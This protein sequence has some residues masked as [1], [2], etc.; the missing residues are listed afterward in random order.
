MLHYRF[1]Y[2][3][4]IESKYVLERI[5]KSW[6]RHSEFL[7]RA[8]M[9]VSMCVCVHLCVFVCVS[10]CVCVQVCVSRCA[11]PCVCVHV[12]VS[13][14]LCPCVCVH[15]CM[16]MCVSMCVRVLCENLILVMSWSEKMVCP[17]SKSK[18]VACRT[19]SSTRGQKVG[20]LTPSL[21]DFDIQR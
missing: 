1:W 15:V 19:A 12:C 18:L 20:F 16:S 6:T 4:C 11:S 2:F 14:C 10:P 8:L 21:H 17:K 5:S 3:N 13:M 7:K 9:C